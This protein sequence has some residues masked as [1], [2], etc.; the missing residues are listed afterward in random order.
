MACP[1]M[2]HTTPFRKPSVNAWLEIPLGF[3]KVTSYLSTQM[4][5]IL[6]LA[7]TIDIKMFRVKMSS[8]EL[9]VSLACRAETAFHVVGTIMLKCG[10]H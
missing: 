8:G 4:P 5:R 10:D 3:R 2:T 1:I 7:G 9:L 6:D